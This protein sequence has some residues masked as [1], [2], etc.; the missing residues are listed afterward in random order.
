MGDGVVVAAEDPVPRASCP[1]LCSKRNRDARW[2]LVFGRARL[3]EDGTRHADIAVPVFGHKSHASIDRRH[4]FIRKWDVTDASRHDGRM[5]RRGLLETTNTGTSVWPT[6][7][8][9]PPRTRPSW[10]GTA[11][12]AR[13]TTASRRAEPVWKPRFDVCSAEKAGAGMAG[14]IEGVDRCQ[15]TLFPERLD[16]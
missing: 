5:L 12:A 2:T 11:S 1:D 4:G 15:S 14:F 9:A 13:S 8:T 7:P 3:R 16:D 10:S 6:A